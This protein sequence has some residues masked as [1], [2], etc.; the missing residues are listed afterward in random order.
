MADKY[1]GDIFLY[2][3][4]ISREGYGLLS[5]AYEQKLEKKEKICLILITRGGD[6]DAAYRMA[7]ATRHHFDHVEVLI[8]DI[9]KSA[10]TLMCIGAEKL[11]FGDRGELGPLDIQLSK[12]DEIL[13][14]MSGLDIIQAI[15]ALKTQVLDSFRTYLMD[16]R[17]GS[18]I[19]TKTAAEIAT[20]LS[21]DFIAPIATKIDPLTLGEH[22]R[23]M[24][25]ASD[26]GKRLDKISK[27]LKPDALVKLVSSYPSHGFVI[28]R[29]EA[30]S[31]FNNVSAPDNSTE[32]VYQWA[33]NIIEE[34]NYPD[35]PVVC[36]VKSE[37]FKVS[38][39]EQGEVDNGIFKP[40]EQRIQ[41][42]D[43]GHDGATECGGKNNESTSVKA[44][45]SEKQII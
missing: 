17:V 44:G 26:Y 21:N 34:I 27:S 28:D 5:T 13:E 41:E 23:A 36:D 43:P 8:P 18:G 14:R 38:N 11:I 1:D 42:N 15:N 3:G 33:R 45:K 9:C 37:A 29:K 10:G 35:S 6:P 39:N 16:I 4:D 40:D 22:L 12:P 20:K 31:L 24:Q 25:I 7:R 19:R 30:A 32:D 2:Y